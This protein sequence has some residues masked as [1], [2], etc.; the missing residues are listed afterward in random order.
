MIDYGVD[1]DLVKKSGAWYTYDGDQLGQGKENARNFLIANPEI[2]NEIE[3][4]ILN[5]LGIGAEAQA[6]RAAEAAAAAAAEKIAEET[7]QAQ[8][9]KAEPAGAMRKGA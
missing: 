6:I 4:K 8:A 9:A 3:Q 1:Q 5:K 7:A 2:A